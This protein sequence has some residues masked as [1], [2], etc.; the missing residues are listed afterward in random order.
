MTDIP[1]P[2]SLV[3]SKERQAI[4]DSI[5][6]NECRRRGRAKN[7]CDSIKCARYKK[8]MSDG[9]LV[10]SQANLAPGHK[11][12]GFRAEESYRDTASPCFVPSAASRATRSAMVVTRGSMSGLLALEAAG[13]SG[14]PLPKRLL[15]SKTYAR[16]LRPLP[17]G[18]KVAM[19]PH[20]S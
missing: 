16:K 19:M 3:P 5:K 12:V 6:K 10:E 8:F 4:D 14:A 7:I 18:P 20:D 9:R 17:A 15:R 1:G 2:P 13:A 11:K